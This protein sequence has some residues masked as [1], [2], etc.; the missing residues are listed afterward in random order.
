[1][2]TIDAIAVLNR[3]LVIEYR[4]L[5]MYLMDATPWSP[6]G[7]ERA[8]SLR[9]IA[10]DQKAAVERL[11]RLILERGGAIETGEYPM[12]YTDTH[13][14]AVDYLLKEVLGYQQ[15]AVAE[16]ERLVP[17][18]GADRPARELAQ[19]VLGSEKAHRDMLASLVAPPQTVGG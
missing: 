12:D 16:I 7:D 2:S 11:A 1:M 15:A 6:S 18:L 17:L 8:A 9:H 4:S 3:L 10:A 13:F 19:E 5:P 14:L